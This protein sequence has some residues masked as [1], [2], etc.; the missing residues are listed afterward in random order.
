MDQPRYIV[1]ISG[2]GYRF[3]AEVEAARPGSLAIAPS[4]PPGFNTAAYPRWVAHLAP[5]VLGTVLLASIA[6]LPGFKKTAR[7]GDLS[8]PAD[9]TTTGSAATPPPVTTS[10]P[11]ALRLYADADARLETYDF[12]ETD[13]AIGMLRETIALD[14]D[15]ASAYLRL[16]QALR[17]R[18]SHSGSAV[19]IDEAGQY[20]E[21][22]LQLAGSVPAREKYYLVGTY[23]QEWGNDPERA[24]VAYAS[25]LAEYP[26]ESRVSIPL[27][28]IYIDN[29]RVAEAAVLIR[30][31]ADSHRS[32]FS[33]AWGAW[34][35]LWLLGETSAAEAIR[36][37]ALSM[38]TPLLR[39]QYADFTLDLE[40]EPVRALINGGNSEAGLQQ[41]GILERR[42]PGA[43]REEADELALHLGTAY[44]QLG[45][46]HKAEVWFQR[47]SD[48]NSIDG[49]GVGYRERLLGA[50]A[51][52]RG[53]SRALRAHLAEY[54]NDEN[55][56]G[57]LILLVMIQAG[58]VQ[59]AERHLSDI[60]QSPS[61]SEVVSAEFD[62]VAGRRRQAI[63]K[64]RHAC[65][66]LR[67]VEPE[68]YAA[69]SASLAR[70]LEAEGNLN[71]AITA[72]APV[73]QMPLVAFNASGALSEARLELAQ[74]YRKAG[75]AA[76]A[77]KLESQLR[78]LYRFADQDFAL[79][80]R[81]ER[82]AGPHTAAALVNP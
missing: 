16:A 18:A 23:Y 71:E 82:R 52:A 70:A 79:S 46:L 39:Q 58:M 20:Y 43:S 8:R 75:R 34:R 42:F 78:E 24:A 41:L 30:N 9:T 5:A 56:V 69:A 49:P 47:Y 54:A 36:V 66:H 68:V 76:E 48:F 33:N 51:L 32:N 14:P 28:R 15:F 2:E 19:K 12:H 81:L 4:P 62:R 59:Q 73:E 40:F 57:P 27:A 74:L 67:Y 1:T 7:P 55:K 44:L 13:A 6:A 64:F 11:E 45:Q 50:V 10:S 65:S 37:R 21:R 31:F 77:E 25:L 38:L 80:A 53:D 17:Y 61:M 72:L 3:I 22:A 26:G 35:M 63:G 29:G 60:K